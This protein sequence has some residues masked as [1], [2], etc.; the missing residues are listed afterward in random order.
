MSFAT[1]D[2]NT[3]LQIER[4]DYASASGIGMTLDV[5]RAASRAWAQSTL[6]TRASLLRSV[7]SRLRAERDSL[8]ATATREMGKPIAQ[9]RAEVEKCASCCDWFADHAAELLAD[10]PMASSARK[11]YVAF[12][13]L[14]VVFAIMPWNYPYWQVARAVIPAIAAGNAVVLKHADNTTRCAL[15]IERIFAEAG[16][17]QGLF[18][19][20]LADYE[21]TDALIADPRIA[22]V[23][24]TG[25]ER[26]GVAVGAAAGAALK[27]CVLELG[28]SDAFVVRADAD[29][30][31]VAASAITARF[32]NNGQSCIA[33]KR[34][35]VHTDVYDAFIE[36]FAQRARA[37]VLDDPGKDTTGLGPVARED[38]RTTMDAQIRDTVAAGARLI[39]GGKARAGAGFFYEATIVVDVLPGM[40]MFDEEVFGPAASITRARDDDHAVEL[41][42]SSS[43]GLGGSVWT[44]DIAAGEVLAARLESGSAFVNAIVASDPRVPFGGVKKSGYGRE[45]SAFGVHAFVNIQTVWV[46]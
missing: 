34:F 30:D 1:V 36:R 7:G 44:R 46:G 10:S 25:S 14:G 26:A 8:A 27:P 20:I 23:T 28:G 19:T 11:S 21:T 12:R 17:P 18:S 5:A 2:P 37:L 40:R 22:A 3:G 45:L 39:T 33:G 35:I 6:D 15:E 31:A 38:L 4:F 42:N 29:L 9:A 43:Y 41:A 13:P 24:L 32:Q 16:A